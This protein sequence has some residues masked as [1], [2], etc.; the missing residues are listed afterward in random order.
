MLRR[1]LLKGLVALPLLAI[2]LPKP[3]RELLRA[4]NH[5]MLYGGTETGRMSHGGFL[6]PERQDAFIRK[7]C[8]QPCLISRDVEWDVTTEMRNGK[9]HIVNVEVVA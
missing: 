2:P 1:E 5:A 9:V 7:L 4:N 8:R 3:D 6:L